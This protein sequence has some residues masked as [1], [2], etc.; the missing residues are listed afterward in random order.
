M[1]MGKRRKD[2]CPLSYWSVVNL[3]KVR[4]QK[5]ICMAR[6]PKDMCPS[7]YWRAIEVNSECKGKFHQS[8]ET[9]KGKTQGKKVFG[10]L[11]RVQS[12]QRHK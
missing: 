7:R 12:H 2:M 1:F 3:I 5:D 9:K 4:R 11:V 8:P 10:P 6:I